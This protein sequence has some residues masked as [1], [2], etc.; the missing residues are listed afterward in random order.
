MKMALGKVTKRIVERL[1]RGALLWDTEVKGF[2]A[3]RQRGDVFYLLRYRINNKQRI[4]S[5]GRHGSPWT[6]D[7][8]R[9]EARR[10]LG[11]VAKGVDPLA[12]RNA[13]PPPTPATI[14]A[15]ISRYL[16][17][18]QPHMKPRAYEEVERHLTK[19]VV[20]L[21]RRTLAEVDR[22]AIAGLLGGIE[23][24]SGPV[25]R[26]RVRSSLSAFWNWAIR[27]GLADINP[28]TG[29]GKAPET[30]RERVLTPTELGAIWRALGDGQ[31]ADIV[32]LL[33]LTGQRREEIGALRWSEIHG[34]A[35]V[36]TPDRTKNRR[37]HTV[38]LS[39]QAKAILKRQVRRRNR[40]YVFG[41]GEGGFSG[42]S[43]AK[44][45]LDQRLALA[46]W[47]LHDLRRSAATG[48]AETGVAPHVIEAVLNHVS[49]Y[50]TGVAGIYN[51]ATYAAECRA[52][53]E[54][55]ADYVE[56]L[57]PSGK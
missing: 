6:P 32:R 40:E 10:L 24:T 44:D 21:H 56:G 33:I 31:F 41:L 38:P 53:L 39:P 48:M 25:A 50:K 11:N 8:A 46:D 22:R 1:D 36:L 45:A 42:W 35:I 7:T 37:A 5:I 4:M 34:D 20:P 2:G 19:H 43:G 12:D 15:E 51:R 47:H 13:P 9:T 27:E 17:Q 57:A 3:R 18:R 14:G 23:T 52:A 54:R 28:V 26:N 55:W 30:T 16:G 29:T 49:G